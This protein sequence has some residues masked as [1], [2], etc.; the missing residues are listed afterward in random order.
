M[1]NELMLIEAAKAVCGTV[2]TFV[3]SCK[4]TGIINKTEMR[5]AEIKI[6]EYLQEQRGNAITA[7]TKNNIL[8]IKSTFDLIQSMELEG[9]A[10]TYAMNQLTTEANLLE[11]LI[12]E[13][14]LK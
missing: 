8:N 10:Y 4:K 1:D 14:K 6:N 7:I 12:E 11:R 13:M 3:T 2:K 9:V 5:Y